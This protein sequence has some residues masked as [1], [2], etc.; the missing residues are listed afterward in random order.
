MQYTQFAMHDQYKQTWGFRGGVLGLNA[1]PPPP[2]ILKFWHSRT[3][4]Q[5]ERKM[6]SVPIPTS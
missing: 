1:P 5:I 2:E 3:G 6:F 4:L